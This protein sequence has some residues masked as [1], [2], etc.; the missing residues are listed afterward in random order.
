MPANDYNASDIARQ[1]VE[2]AVGRGA[3]VILGG[4]R[5]NFRA[6]PD[7]SQGHNSMGLSLGCIFCLSNLNSVCVCVLVFYSFFEENTEL[8]AITC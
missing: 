4:G 6:A 5:A 7:P 1:M 2:S 3:D 8:S